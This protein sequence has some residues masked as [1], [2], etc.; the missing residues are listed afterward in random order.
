MRLQGVL[1]DERHET[2]EGRQRR[3][4][5]GSESAHSR[6]RN[7]FQGRML[8]AA[9]I[10][11]V[12]HDQRVVDHHAAQADDPSAVYYNPAGIVQLEG[13]Q[14][15]AGLATILNPSLGYD[16]VAVLVK[17]GLASGKTLKTLVLEKKLMSEDALENLLAAAFGPNLA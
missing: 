14:I 11:I 4:Q 12:D 1:E 15:S 16:Q 17:E 6:L 10:G 5:N 7:G 3:E 8:P 2:T 9:T 13:T